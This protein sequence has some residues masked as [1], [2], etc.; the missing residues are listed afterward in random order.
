MSNRTHDRAVNPGAGDKPIGPINRTPTRTSVASAMAT[1]TLLAANANRLGATVF[2]NS[3]ANLYLALG[4]GAGTTNFTIKLAAGAYYPIPFGFTG[5]ISGIW[6][7]VNG[8]AL[9]TEL[10]A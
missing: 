3:T 2:N 10:T 9:V 5:I 4:A 8:N 1:T 6:D 7:A